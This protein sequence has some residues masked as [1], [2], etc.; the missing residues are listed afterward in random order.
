MVKHEADRFQL[1]I[2]KQQEEKVQLD[3]EINDCKQ[4]SIPMTEQLKQ[5]QETEKRFS[6]ITKH[7]TMIETQ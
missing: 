2:Q 7:K 4:R 3:E 5:I 6:N 1:E